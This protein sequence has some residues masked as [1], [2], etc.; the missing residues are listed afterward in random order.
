M[1]S[2]FLSMYQ[3]VDFSTPNILAISWMDFILFLQPTNVLFHLHGEL[4]FTQNAL[5]MVCCSGTTCS[6]LH[7]YEMLKYIFCVT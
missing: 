1:F 6:H 5:K 7:I 3:T 2:V 4:L